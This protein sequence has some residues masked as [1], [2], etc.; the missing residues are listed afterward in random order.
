MT[1]Q[2]HPQRAWVVV[3]SWTP[4]SGREGWGGLVPQQRSPEGP[5]GQGC[6]GEGL[7][8][9]PLPQEGLYSTPTEA[10]A[11]RDLMLAASTRQPVQTAVDPLGA[12][13]Q[14]RA[15]FSS[16]GQ[17]GRRTLGVDCRG[18][19]RGGRLGWGG[20]RG[21]MA[22]A[23]CCRVP[24]DGAQ[25]RWGPRVSCFSSDRPANS[26]RSGVATI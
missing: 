16:A 11:I 17:H 9:Q 23:A 7:G 14:P 8:R 25:Q 3:G 10:C 15:P 19:G 5:A 12:Y 20:A 6:R 1:L 18:S 21:P 13:E 2:V 22:E 4:R 24:A 26:P